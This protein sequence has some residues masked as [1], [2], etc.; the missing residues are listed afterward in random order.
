MSMSNKVLP[1]PVL[2]D[3][4]VMPGDKVQMGMVKAIGARLA[5]ESGTPC[6]AFWNKLEQVLE[7]HIVGMNTFSFTKDGEKKYRID[8]EAISG[9]ERYGYSFWLNENFFTDGF[10]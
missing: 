3:P 5:I 1:F 7:D 6:R 2:I 9:G 10:W 8:F 4:A